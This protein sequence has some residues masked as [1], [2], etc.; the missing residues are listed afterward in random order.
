MDLYGK[1]LID[2][3]KGLDH[4]LMLNTSYETTEEMPIWYFFREYGDMSELEKMALSICEGHVL[5]VGAGTG[6]HSLVL[7]QFGN[8]V[9]AIDTC[10]E[11]VEIMLKSGVEN[12]VKEDFF[13]LKNRAFDTILL[14]MNGIGIIGSL[15]RFEA[16]LDHAKGLLK[17]EGQLIFDSSDIRYL[18]KDQALPKDKYYG[19]VS[20]QYEYLGEKG[21]WF[22]WVYIDPETL[23]KIADNAGWFVYF[24]MNDENDQYLVRMI[25]K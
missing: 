3:S 2:F 22:D 16:F 13:N 12:A 8:E 19:E 9:S 15:D 25:P 23:S 10:E 24:L 18:Y 21:D 11:A 17:P 20:F 5:D 6:V 7:Q 1:A 4:T 14:L